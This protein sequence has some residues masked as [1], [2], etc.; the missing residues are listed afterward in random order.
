NSAYSWTHGYLN[1]INGTA[2]SVGGRNNTASG[3]DSA[4]FGNGNIST[5]N[6]SFA[7]GNGNTVG[8]HYARSLGGYKGSTLY[9]GELLV[10]AYRD[11]SLGT[12]PFV[13]RR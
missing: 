5:A 2:C 11:T 7:F 13:S 8:H 3:S 4:V 12:N 1:T 6:Y 10:W 9:Q